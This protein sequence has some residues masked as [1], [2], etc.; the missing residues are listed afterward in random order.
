MKTYHYLSG[1]PRSGNTLLSA[2][3][4]QNPE[5]YCSPLSPISSYLY[6]LAEE[7]F[8]NEHARRTKDPTGFHS[9]MNGM[10]NNYYSHIQK[11]VIIDRE[12][13]W[14]TP[15]NLN[16]LKYYVNNEPKIIFTVRPIIEILA[17]FISILPE[18]SYIDREMQQSGWWI[19]PSLS[20]NDNRCDY[21]MRP[22]GLIDQTILSYEEISKKEN[23]GIF[24][25]VEYDEL[26]NNPQ[27]V[28]N[29]IY[30]FLG[31][32]QFKHNFTNVKRLEEQ[33]NIGEPINLHEVRSLVKKVSKTPKDV[34][35]PY[36]LNRY[37]IKILW[38]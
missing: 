35:S 28:M 9:L 8:V 12:K 19:K 30:T 38:Q 25:I 20:K 2:I 18:D 36:V 4:N 26:T 24:H 6:N 27:D 13:C 17:S 3:L 34:L 10:I 29:K 14:G 15:G 33:N 23:K 11:P 32:E 5:I 21:L 16:N 31:L 1:L 37:N 22:K 7:N